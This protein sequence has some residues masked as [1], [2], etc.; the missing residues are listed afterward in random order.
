MYTTAG[1]YAK[2]LVVCRL[3]ILVALRKCGSSEAHNV[4]ISLNAFV[5][6]CYVFHH[7][8]QCLQANP[9]KNQ[10]LAKIHVFLTRL[11]RVKEV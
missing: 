7:T 1:N 9:N 11:N 8:S 3:R 5:Q 6:T 2:I 10:I 4:T